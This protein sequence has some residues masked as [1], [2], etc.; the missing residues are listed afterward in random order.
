MA[1]QT[2]YDDLQKQLDALR[3]DFSDL[4][5]TLKDV[6]A[7]YAHQGQERL[8]DKADYLQDQAKL[9]ARRAQAEVEA[10]PFTSVAFA[11]GIGMIIGKVL[12]R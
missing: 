5:A 12:D 9:S 6:T 1:T 11:F 7:S 2:S 10:H 8:K 3:K 4:T